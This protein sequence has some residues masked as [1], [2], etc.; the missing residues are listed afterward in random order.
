MTC[1]EHC[2]CQEVQPRPSHAR[3]NH[4]DT[5]HV[6]QEGTERAPGC[7]AHTPSPRQQGLGTERGWA[8]V[9]LGTAAPPGQDPVPDA[10]LSTPISHL[11]Q[12]SSRL[13]VPLGHLSLCAPRG[14]RAPT[15]LPTQLTRPDLT[16]PFRGTPAPRPIPSSHEP[17]RTKGA[18]ASV[19]PGPGT[20]RR[21]AGWIP[22]WPGVAS[23]CP[24]EGHTSLKGR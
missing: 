19:W 16:H 7:E 9:G 8:R 1:C 12:P 17:H 21:S 22:N 15:L 14:R 24:A 4:G 23:I 6:S 5:K 10:H 11:C 3:L 2:K 18:G 13:R 20:P